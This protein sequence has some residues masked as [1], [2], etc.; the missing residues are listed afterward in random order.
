LVSEEPSTLEVMWRT[1]GVDPTDLRVD[2]SGTMLAPLGHASLDLEAIVA[3]LPL[4]LDVPGGDEVALGAHLGEGGMGEVRLGVQK[5]LDREVAVKVARD[6]ASVAATL[7][8]LREARVTGLLEHPN[9]VP[10]HVLGRDGQGR[11][12]LVMKRIEGVAWS[13][14]IFARP[15]QASAENL[16]YHL[17]VLGQVT[18]A[19]SFAHAK[20][21]VHLDIKPENVMIGPFG[22]VYLLDWGVAARLTKDAAHLDVPLASDIDHIVGTPQ[23]MAPEMACAEGSS[24]NV[25]TDVYLLGACLHE[26]LTGEPPHEGASVREVLESAFASEP[27]DYAE[28]WPSE[29]VYICHRAM[30]R[31]SS[32]R[33]ASAAEFSAALDAFREHRHSN[34]LAVE[35]TRRLT[36]L[37]AAIGS[38]KPD[39][40]LEEQRSIYDAFGAC[41]FGFHQALR[42]D[43]DNKTAKRGLQRC[44]ERMIE[45]ELR[46]GAA[47]AAAAYLTEL[48]RPNSKLTQRVASARRREQQKRAALEQLRHD[49]DVTVG[50]RFRGVA[51]LAIAMLW[52]AAHFIAGGL[53]RSGTEVAPRHMLAVGSGF[54]VASIALAVGGRRVFFDTSANTRTSWGL[55]IAYLGYVACFLVGTVIDAP[56]SACLAFVCVSSAMLWGAGALGSDRRLL[57]LPAALGSTAFAITMLPHYAFEL[58]AIGA[59]VGPIAVGVMWLRSSAPQPPQPTQPAKPAPPTDHSTAARAPS[60]AASAQ[61]RKPVE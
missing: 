37:E 39:D 57:P 22:E 32:H 21:I 35:A 41:R 7:Q 45:F 18:R 9:V 27:V 12:V 31:V 28:V 52:S 34:E 29:L 55:I 44:L 1:R 16:G 5:A 42:D 2:E 61:Q 46:R 30:H 24:L 53:A 3:K 59:L 19:L 54:L 50:D 20:G 26:V 25:R 11:P 51:A 58:M 43:P 4:L 33:Y 47:G 17:E 48:P 15:A 38:S 49:A 14:A 10:I 8:L 40:G 6:R 23:Y 56:I 36:L 60:P 13:E